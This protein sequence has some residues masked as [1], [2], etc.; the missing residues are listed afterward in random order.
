MPR[1]TYAHLPEVFKSVAQDK[2]FIAAG[3]R[4]GKIRQLRRGLYTTNMVD[5]PELVVRKNLWQIVSILCPGGLVSHR[6]ALDAAPSPS[7][8]VFVTTSSNHPINL[9][10]YQIRQI[11]GPGPLD[12]DRPFLGD[13]RISSQPRFLLECLTGNAYADKSPYLS[14]DV[15]EK[16]LDNQLSLGED[17]VNRVRDLAKPISEALG[18]EKSFARLDSIIGALLG[19]R[20]ASLHSAAGVARSRGLPFDSERLDQFQAL[21]QALNDWPATPRLDAHLSGLP[22]QHIA[23]FDA[24]FSNYIEGTEFEVDEAKEI[25]LK[26]KIPDK[27][28]ADGRDILGTF[29]VVSDTARMSTKIS[30][31]SAD[32]FV[33]LVKRWHAVIMQGRPER[34]PGQ[35]KITSN[36]AG[37]TIFVSPQRTEGTLRQGFEMGRAIISPFGR[38]AYL[39]YL[40]SEVHPFDDGNGRL[41][42]A[43]VNAELVSH[44]E[45]RIIIPTSYRIEYIDALKRLSRENDPKLLPRMLD[46][47]QDF[48]ASID[49]ADIAEAEVQLRAWNA[50]DEGP[51]AFLQRPR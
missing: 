23:F 40:L 17:A 30:E 1:N 36:R 42:R 48:A 44:G 4:D 12:G 3:I 20:K 31:L 35:F 10:G 11:N 22:F 26:A 43:V 21:Y 39:M 9:P 25:A 33:E 34:R 19:T 50:F 27:R 14:Q 41:T 15:I 13:L 32:A 8:V 16:Y 24:Y 37:A 28:P 6:T 38:A 46:F 29:Q 2:N 5:P 47:A 18:L 7:G 51:R 49:F 45:R